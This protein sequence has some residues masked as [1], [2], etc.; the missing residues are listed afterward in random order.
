MQRPD[1]F[2]CRRRTAPIPIS[3]AHGNR[4][5]IWLI[6]FRR[7]CPARSSAVDCLAYYWRAADFLR[8]GDGGIGGLLEQLTLAH[9]AAFVR[10]R[11]AAPSLPNPTLSLLHQRRFLLAPPLSARLFLGRV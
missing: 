8:G 3:G 11:R 4:Q 7:P 6:M 5:N 1:L 2:T 9:G 10:H